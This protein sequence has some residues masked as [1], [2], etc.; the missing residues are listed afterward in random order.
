MEY[1]IIGIIKKL[2]SIGAVAGKDTTSTLPTENI[3]NEGLR[4]VEGCDELFINGSEVSTSLFFF[5]SNS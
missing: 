1:I 5:D 3:W 2:T 4:V